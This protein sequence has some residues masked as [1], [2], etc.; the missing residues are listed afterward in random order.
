MRQKSHSRNIGVTHAATFNSLLT[1]KD[2]PSSKSATLGPSSLRFSSSR[3]TISPSSQGQSLVSITQGHVAGTSLPLGRKRSG[4]YDEAEKDD[5]FEGAQDLQ[6][7][8][9]DF[10][11]WCCKYFADPLTKVCL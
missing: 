10:C 4:R 2:G 8:P 11:D 9:T 6:P 1:S 5:D 7:L 3:H